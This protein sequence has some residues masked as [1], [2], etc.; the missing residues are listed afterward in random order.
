MSVILQ[1]HSDSVAA[2]LDGFGVELSI[3]FGEINI[4]I[5]DQCDIH[6]ILSIHD[7]FSN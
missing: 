7:A 5:N 6:S 4:S 1:K 2:I 3:D